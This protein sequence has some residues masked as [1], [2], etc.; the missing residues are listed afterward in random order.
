MLQT[1]AEGLEGNLLRESEVEILAEAVV[2]EVAALDG[3]PALEREPLPERRTR[4]AHEEPRQA[5]VPL[6]HGFRDSSA[7]FTREPVGQ[8]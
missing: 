5:V 4:Q 2:A 8:E 3:G 7:A 6:E 1:G